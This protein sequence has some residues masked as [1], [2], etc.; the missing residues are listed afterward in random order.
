MMS[1]LRVRVRLALILLAASTVVGQEA[2]LKP[3]TVCEILNDLKSY[4]GQPVA[5]LGRFSFR[6]EG[7]WLGEDQCEAQPAGDS[8]RVSSRPPAVLWL[9]LDTTSAPRTKTGYALDASTVTQKLQLVKKHT[10][11]GQFRFGS[12][13]YDRWAVVYGRVKVREAAAPA[14]DGKSEGSHSR[15]SAPADLLYAGD[16]YVMFLHEPSQ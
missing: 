6:R 2:P 15:D 8:S 16:G 10:K 5:V 9:S 1:G 12:T 3:V 14:S 11:L 7:R 13:D 4:D